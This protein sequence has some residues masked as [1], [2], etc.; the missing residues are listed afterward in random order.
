MTGAR[1]LWSLLRHDAATLAAVYGSG[2]TDG[3]GCPR[4]EGRV[5]GGERAR[6]VS[7]LCWRCHGCGA[8]GTTVE[9]VIQLAQDPDVARRIEGGA[10]CQTK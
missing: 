3:L 8:T 1:L 5:A 10:A 4:C 6:P 9:L 7:A 2:V